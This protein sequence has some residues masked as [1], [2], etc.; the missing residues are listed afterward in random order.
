MPAYVTHP[1]GQLAISPTNGRI[2]FSVGGLSNT[3]VPD[4]SDWEIGWLRD[5][6]FMHEV[7]GTNI[8]LTGQN[9]TSDN[10]LTMEPKDKATTG[11]M[12]PFGTPSFKGQKIKGETRWY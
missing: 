2:F 5:M 6:P 11:G 3:A 1:L 9:F 10:F 4:I 8:T 12:M 7:P